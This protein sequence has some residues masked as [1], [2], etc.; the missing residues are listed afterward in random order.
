MTKKDRTTLKAFFRD[1]ALP[2]A[3]HYR[4]LIDSG[5]NQIEDGYAK[6]A[7]DGLRLTSVG[8]SERVLSL[9]ESLSATY[10]AWVIDHGKD[11]S[12]LHFRRGGASVDEVP[13]ISFSPEGRVGVYNEAPEWPLDVNGVARSR[14]RIGFVT[15]GIPYVP[16]DGVW[17]DIIDD[18]TGCHAFEIMAGA[19][20]DPRQGRYSMLRAVAMNAYHPRNWI[21]NKIFGRRK[22][23]AQHAVYG[24]YADRIRLRWVA[25]DA[26]HHYKLQMRTNASFGKDKVI[27]YYVTRLWFDPTMA[28]SRGGPAREIDLS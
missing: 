15:D 25:K 13:G 9:Y 4:D 22:I 28:G 8:G 1:G 26:A 6:T 10:P 27:R 11:N 24:S 17:H 20:A 3:E 21:L 14:G 12:S 16:A 23:K 7:A 18:L 5:V 19:G 2:T